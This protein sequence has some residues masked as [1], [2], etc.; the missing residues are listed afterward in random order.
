MKNFFMARSNDSLSHT[1]VASKTN[2][3]LLVLDMFLILSVYNIKHCTDYLKGFL[4]VLLLMLREY[5]DLD[6]L[7]E[8]TG[9]YGYPNGTRT[10]QR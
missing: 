1:Y 9:D 8:L 5:E 7:F 6:Q 2:F 10:H 3:H 4:Y